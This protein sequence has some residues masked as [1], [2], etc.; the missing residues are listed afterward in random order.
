ME[1]GENHVETALR[2]VYEESGVKA[3]VIKYIGKS[4]YSFS[5]PQDTVEKEVHWYLMMA[6]NYYSKPQREE[7]FVDSGYY[8]YHEAYHL[9]KFSNEKQILEQAYQEYINLKK[10]KQWI[11]P[12]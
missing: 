6:D 7:F 8:K 4:E 3:T 12:R 5:V 2:E 9:L 1:T 10:N 11:K